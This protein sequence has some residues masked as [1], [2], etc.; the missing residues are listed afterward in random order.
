MAA[1]LSERGS[2]EASLVIVPLVFLFLIGMQLAFSSHARNM[3]TIFAQDDASVRAIVGQFSDL[4][5]FIAIESSGEGQ[6][7]DLLVTSRER[8]LINLIP[9]LPQ[10]LGR[11]A[12]VSVKGLAVIENSR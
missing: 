4:D 5:E 6:K 7:I 2:A 1:L 8:S 9:S 10:I 3:Q 12:M 11:Q